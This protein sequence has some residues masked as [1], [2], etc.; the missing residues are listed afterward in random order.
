[1]RTAAPL[2]AAFL[3]AQAVARPAQET[4]PPAGPTVTNAR[5]YTV[6][7]AHPVADTLAVRG[8]TVQFVE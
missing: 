3:A 7:E 1:M 2:A 8:S 5:I 6:D 4:R